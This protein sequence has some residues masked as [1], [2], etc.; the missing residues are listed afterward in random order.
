MERIGRL[1]ISYLLVVGDL[2]PEEDFDGLIVIF[3]ALLV[4]VRCFCQ[5]RVG[6]D[7]GPL[8]NARDDAGLGFAFSTRT[9]HFSPLHQ[10]S[11]RFATQKFVM[12]IRRSLIKFEIAPTC[13]A[14]MEDINLLFHEID[15][16]TSSN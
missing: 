3:D 10:R 11:L 9:L 2:L 16:R 1:D 8:G 12:N 7:F 15:R 13:S 6:H 5:Q 4:K 14:R